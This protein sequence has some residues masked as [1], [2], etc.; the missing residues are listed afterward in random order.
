MGADSDKAGAEGIDVAYVAHLA[1]LDLT[2][3]EIETFQEQLE[4]IVGY[5]NK[6]QGLD[7]EG[8]E[9][10]SHAR[11]VMNVFRE[12]KVQPGLDREVVLDNAPARSMD[13]FTVPRIIE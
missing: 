10:T 2:T 13:Q 3:D 5:V 9:P 7:L 11:P 1:R 12:D 6:L 8:I 4:H